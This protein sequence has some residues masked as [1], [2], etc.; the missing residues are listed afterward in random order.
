[1]PDHARLCDV[2]EAYADRCEAL[3]SLNYPALLVVVHVLVP[4]GP[5][6]WWIQVQVL[7]RAEG[8]EPLPPLCVACV[9]EVYVDVAQAARDHDV[10]HADALPGGGVLRVVNGG[11]ELVQRC[12]QKAVPGAAAVKMIATPGIEPP[13][14]KVLMCLGIVPVLVSEQGQVC[15]QIV[16][17]HKRVM[18]KRVYF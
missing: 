3:L 5:G 14:Y 9:G 10:L 1:M 13:P 11:Q 15:L 18:P 2:V 17:Q 16:R 8:V 4:C 12:L 7:P 6:L